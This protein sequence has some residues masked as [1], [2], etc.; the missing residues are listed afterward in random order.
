L[1]RTAIV[2]ATGR[3]EYHTRIAGQVT[4]TPID[5]TQSPPVPS[6]ASFQAN[7]EDMQRGT[8]DPMGGWLLAETK[9]IAPQKGGS[10]FLMTR[11]RVS[12]QGQD[13]YRAQARC[14]APEP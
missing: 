14:L 11:L 6:G 5:V 12:S 10:E 4:V 8:I 1:D 7:V 13:S 3:Y 2:D 9:R